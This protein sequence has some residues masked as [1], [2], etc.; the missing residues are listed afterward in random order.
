M[1]IRMDWRT[2]WTT[3]IP[4]RWW[5]WPRA[6][7]IQIFCLLQWS[8]SHAIKLC[9]TQNLGI[10]LKD[11]W[12]LLTLRTLLATNRTELGNHRFGKHRYCEPK[13]SIQNNIEQTA[14]NGYTTEDKYESP[15]QLIIMIITTNMYQVQ[16]Q[17]IINWSHSMLDMAS[18][19]AYQLCPHWPLD[20]QNFK[21]FNTLVGTQTFQNRLCLA[22]AWKYHMMSST[23]LIPDK[24]FWLAVHNRGVSDFN[25]LE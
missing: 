24:G 2:H 18:N 5:W 16:I 17:P 15:E 25:S 6:K 9:K 13:A 22:Y 11:P 19:V 4:H 7:T 20:T 14:D 8:F 23:D 10:G 1:D 21:Y 12:H 3:T